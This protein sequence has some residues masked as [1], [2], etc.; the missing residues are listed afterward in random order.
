MSFQQTG[1]LCIHLVAARM[2][3]FNGPCAAWTEIESANQQ[4]NPM[5]GKPRAHCEVKHRSDARITKDLQYVVDQL[6]LHSSSA[7]K[8]DTVTTSRPLIAVP[9]E[10]NARRGRLA[11]IRPLQPQRVA[12]RLAKKSLFLADLLQQGKRVTY[13]S[14]GDHPRDT[15]PWTLSNASD[16]LLDAEELSFNS[17]DLSRWASPTYE[18]RIEEMELFVELLNNLSDQCGLHTWF[19]ISPSIS[20]HVTSALGSVEA[21]AVR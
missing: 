1:K 4:Q 6:E 8:K 21:M 9:A 13:K 11:R 20:T 19:C 5:R 18:L 12:K 16:D 17:R 10:T 7:A 15:K 3:H 2:E 14:A